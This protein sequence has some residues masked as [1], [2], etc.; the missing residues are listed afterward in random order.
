MDR[1][2]AIN[3]ILEYYQWG[4]ENTDAGELELEL[5]SL[6]RDGFK[7]L[8]NWTDEELATEYKRATD[9]LKEYNPEWKDKETS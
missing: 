9:W 6:Y 5:Q 4:W 7:G 8:E 1:E 3:T 2:H